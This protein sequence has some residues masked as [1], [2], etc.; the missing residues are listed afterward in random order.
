MNQVTDGRQVEAC[1]A[2]LRDVP[3]V[4][5]VEVMSI[6]NDAHVG[7]VVTF[8]D[9]RE[10]RVRRHSTFV[11]EIRPEA[12]RETLDRYSLPLAL[13]LR[14]EVVVTGR[15]GIEA[16]VAS[17]PGCGATIGLGPLMPKGT[18]CLSCDPSPDVSAT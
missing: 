4:A 14:E 3:G 15:A 5:D 6:Y 12:V 2:Y 16:S 9:G 18:L 10:C 13:Q 11:S 7:F 8:N 1:S 17:C